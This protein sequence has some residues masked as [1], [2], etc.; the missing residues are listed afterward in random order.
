[1][2]KG[3]IHKLAII[4]LFILLAGTNL[5]YGSECENFVIDYISESEFYFDSNGCFDCIEGSVVITAEMAQ[6]CVPTEFEYEWVGLVYMADDFSNDLYQVWCYENTGTQPREAYLY[7]SPS[8]VLY[9]YQEG[10]CEP[11][12][13]P[14]SISGSTLVYAGL[15]YD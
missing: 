2:T 12:A 11:A 14:G 15:S 13:T 7:L 5:Y 6:N 10:A 9:I 1:M 3:I 4:C 8:D